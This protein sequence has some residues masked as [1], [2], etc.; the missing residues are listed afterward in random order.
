MSTFTRM[1]C[2]DVAGGSAGNFLFYVPLNVYA[3]SDTGPSGLVNPFATQ[4]LGS[5]GAAKGASAGFQFYRCAHQ[6]FKA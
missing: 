3:N 5:G 6:P 4:M 2:S 1:S